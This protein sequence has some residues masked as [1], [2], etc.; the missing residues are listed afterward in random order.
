MPG[1][2]EEELPRLARDAGLEPLGFVA[3]DGLPSPRDAWRILASGSTAPTARIPLGG[4]DLA[5]RVE[6]EWRR[7]AEQNGLFDGDGTFLIMPAAP[8]A[9]GVPWLK[10]RLTAQARLAEVLVGNSKPGQAEFAAIDVGGTVLCG[11]TTEDDDVWLVVDR[12]RLRPDR[13]ATDS[14]ADPEAVDLSAIDWSQ[15][16]VLQTSKYFL[17][18]RLRPPY[19]DGWA[20]LGFL[21]SGRYLARVHEVPES[22]GET[23]VADLIGAPVDQRAPMLPLTAEQAET[24]GA[25]LGVPINDVAIAY[26]LEFLTGE[27]KSEL[28]TV[29]RRLP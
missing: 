11:A 6:A 24:L 2:I 18:D 29:K 14:A 17:P 27:Q 9:D 23:E 5:G 8:G 25:R 1:L 7:L 3:A 4:P 15:L 22:L 21:R 13:A 12:E 19:R 10:V 20:L 26:Y 28:K 16:G